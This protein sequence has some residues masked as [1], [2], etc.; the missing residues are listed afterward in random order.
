MKKK[1]PKR[2]WVTRDPRV[3]NVEVRNARD[4]IDK[5]N[6]YWSTTVRQSDKITVL[7]PAQCRKDFGAYPRKG[8]CW[9]VEEKKD[10]VLWLRYDHLYGIGEVIQI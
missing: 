6:A 4:G 10:H 3:R 8:E 5:S 2:V 9:L 1:Y 7:S